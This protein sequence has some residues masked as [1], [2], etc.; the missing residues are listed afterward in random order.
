MDNLFSEIE[1]VGYV[2]NASEPWAL[3]RSQTPYLSMMVREVYET[4]VLADKK[5][6][7]HAYYMLKKDYL[8][9]T[10]TTTNAIEDHS[11]SIPGLQRFGHHATDDEL[12]K[13][14][15]QIRSRLFP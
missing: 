6:L 14:F 4:Q 1:Q 11:S 13:F 3:N 10:D 12:L 7:E 5:W 2:P 15:S 8:F 9:W